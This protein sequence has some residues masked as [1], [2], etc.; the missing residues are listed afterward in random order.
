M[1]DHFVKKQNK[2][3]LDVQET[4]CV[5]VYKC[6]RDG[7]ETLL[8]IKSVFG[9]GQKCMKRLLG[10]LVAERDKSDHRNWNFA[11]LEAAK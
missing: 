8:K 3:K 1:L 2:K 4:V 7:G 5:C 10:V 11:L 6:V 9:G